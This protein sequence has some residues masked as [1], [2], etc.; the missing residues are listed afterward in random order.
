MKLTESTL[1]STKRVLAERKVQKYLKEGLNKDQ[2]Q[3]KLIEEGFGDFIRKGVDKVKGMTGLG[4]TSLTHKTMGQIAMLKG[5]YVR[6]KEKFYPDAN[7]VKNFIEFVEQN[8]RKQA[9]GDGGRRRDDAWRAISNEKRKTMQ[10]NAGFINKSRKIV[11][12]MQKVSYEAY[13][14]G[15]RDDKTFK[16]IVTPY[17]K[18]LDE[19]V[20]GMRDYLKELDRAIKVAQR[21]GN[22]AG[23][24]EVYQEQLARERYMDKQQARADAA[25]AA[26]QKAEKNKFRGAKKNPDDDMEFTGGQ[27]S[28]KS[29]YAE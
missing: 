26:A 15:G 3:A 24:K 5:E 28:T 29:R 19:E 22:S 9:G 16:K 7:D 27:M 11:R 12:E 23:L 4:K 13:G 2:I 10:S 17:I 1:N 8:A 20:E 14:K 6:L 18:A 25:F 21:S